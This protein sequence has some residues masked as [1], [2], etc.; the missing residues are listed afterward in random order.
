MMKEPFLFRQ[1]NCLPM[2]CSVFLPGFENAEVKIDND[3]K[4][5]KEL[6][7]VLKQ[8]CCLK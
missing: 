5:G 8:N 1:I 2:D 6:I 7:V 3:Y 4:K